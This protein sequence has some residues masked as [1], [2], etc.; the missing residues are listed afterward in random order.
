MWDFGF[1]AR[2]E[3]HAPLALKHESEPLNLTKKLPSGLS[4]AFHFLL[5]GKGQ[6]QGIQAAVASTQTEWLMNHRNFFPTVLEA[7]KFTIKST[8]M[9]LFW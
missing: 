5:G 6:C 9:V 2:I 7:G 4:A 8:S 1:L 3:L